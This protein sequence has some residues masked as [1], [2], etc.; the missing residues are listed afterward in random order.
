MDRSDCDYTYH[1]I[2]YFFGS[3]R[4][5]IKLKFHRE[6]IHAFENNLECQLF[7]SCVSG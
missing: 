1:F 2:N 4:V 5:A 6:A 7:F 3:I